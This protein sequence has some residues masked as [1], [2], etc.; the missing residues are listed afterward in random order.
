MYYSYSPCMGWPSPWG[1]PMQM[2]Y[3]MD[4]PWAYPYGGMLQMPYYPPPGGYGAP[5]MS[6]PYGQPD[7]PPPGGYGAPG[8]SPYGQPMA[9]EQEINYLR[10]HAQM[11]KQQ[12]D[13]IEDRIKELEKKA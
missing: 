2:G 9:P 11:L 4:G 1:P 10:D 7:Y 3:P 12:M 5:G 8:M 6:S 13:Q